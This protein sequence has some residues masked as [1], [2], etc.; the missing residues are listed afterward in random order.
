MIPELANLW[1]FLGAVLILNLTPGPDMMYCA[2]NGLS[3][4]ARAGFTSAVGVGF[5]AIFHSALA[6]VGITALIAASDIAFDV[7][8][9][10][11]AVYLIWMGY[12]QLRAPAAQATSVLL[13]RRSQKSIFTRGLITNILNPKVALFFIAFLPQF[14][15]V[16]HGNPAMQ[17]MFLGAL[18][19]ISGTLI[20]GSVGAFA[21]R[22]STYMSARYNIGNW[23][24]KFS[25]G[26]MILLGVRLFFMEKS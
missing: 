17:I 25:G 2:A 20:N 15:S 4:G 9:I 8:R 12:R 5:G 19:G 3:Q 26:V 24:S 6:A 14:I 23:I 13:P 16:E 22:A 11:G 7:I 21:G 1:L 18:V 10:F